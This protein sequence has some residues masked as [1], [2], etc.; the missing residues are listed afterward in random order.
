M[1]ILKIKLNADLNNHAIDE[2]AGEIW[3]IHS[4]FCVMLTLAF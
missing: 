1:D 2:L 3:D 4:H